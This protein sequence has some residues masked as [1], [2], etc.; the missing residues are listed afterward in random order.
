MQGESEASGPD[1]ESADGDR[2][3]P[4]GGPSEVGATAS[5]SQSD[6]PPA[7]SS[8]KPGETLAEVQADAAR[9]KDAL[10]RTAA[11]FDNFRKR[12]EKELQQ[13]RHRGIEQHLRHRTTFAASNDIF[14]SRWL[15]PADRGAI[16]RCPCAERSAG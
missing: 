16:E 6:A 7:P 13:Q 4:S 10:L 8:R 9:L 15:Q 1:D 14:G 12:T 5:T 11:D 3:T 2:A